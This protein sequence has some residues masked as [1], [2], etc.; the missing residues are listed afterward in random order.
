MPAFDLAYIKTPRKFDAILNYLIKNSFIKIHLEKHIKAPHS[1]I[2]IFSLKHRSNY[3]TF[4]L[5]DYPTN[6]QIYIFWSFSFRQGALL[7]VFML[8]SNVTT[9]LTLFCSWFWIYVNQNVCR[10]LILREL[11]FVVQ[12]NWKCCT[13]LI[14]FFC[15][16]GMRIDIID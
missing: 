1:I 5:F 12:F 7:R 16:Y 10:I 8:N 2:S 11:T 9:A 14:F 15:L 6:L 13:N 4:R 3:T